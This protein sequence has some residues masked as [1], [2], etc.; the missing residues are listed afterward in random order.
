MNREEKEAAVEKIAAKLGDADTIFAID[1]RGISVPQAAELRVQLREAETT[2]TVVKNRLAKRAVEQAG[3]AELEQ[4][5]S[6]PT[7]LAFVKG[8]AVLAAKAIAGF[9]REHSVLAYKGGLMDGEPLDPDSFTTIARLPGLDVLRGQ[10]AALAASPITGLVR[11]LGQMVGGLAL[12]LGEIREKG[13]VGG[14]PAE[15]A[16]RAASAEDEA[17]G[18]DDD[19]S[20]Q[21]DAAEAAAGSEGTEKEE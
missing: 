16:E 3:V 20:P 13:L 11:G 9:T 12:Q 10:L 8:D 1:F 18:N 2:F 21:E 15:P 4:H 19:D 7:A 17:S 6:G 14:Q 5:L